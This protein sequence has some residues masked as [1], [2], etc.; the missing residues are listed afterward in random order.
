VGQVPEDLAIELGELSLRAGHYADARK[1][2]EA[3]LRD[4]TPNLRS[5]TVRKRLADMAELEA[6]AKGARP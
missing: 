6:Q 1:Y 5:V 2:F 4:F 3:Y